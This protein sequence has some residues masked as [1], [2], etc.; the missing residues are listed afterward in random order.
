MEF[1]PIH[2]ADQDHHWPPPLFL[3]TSQPTQ[4]SH[5]DVI[6]SSLVPNQ[7]S[8]PASAKEPACRC[9]RHGRWR[10]IPGSGRSPGAGNSNPLKYSCLEN[11]MD[12]RSVEGYGPWDHKESDTTEWLTLSLFTF[13]LTYDLWTW[14]VGEGNNARPFAV[15]L[16][17]KLVWNPLKDLLQSR[18]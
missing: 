10:S 8:S 18:E 3:I 2:G 15:V 4:V 5:Q 7:S 11:P 14:R 1:F 13:L 17:L 6:L 16:W 9:R 12:K